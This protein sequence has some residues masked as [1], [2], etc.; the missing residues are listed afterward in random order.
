MSGHKKRGLGTPGLRNTSS[1]AALAFLKDNPKSYPKPLQT[2]NI[3]PCL[4][5]PYFYGSQSLLQL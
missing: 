2:K 5:K 4:Q 1:S 3:G